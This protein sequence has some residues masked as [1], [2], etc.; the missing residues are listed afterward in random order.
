MLNLPPLN[1]EKTNLLLPDLRT[2]E[3]GL[4]STDA[5]ELAACLFSDSIL[6]KPRLHPTQG[7][8][9]LKLVS[10]AEGRSES[11][12]SVNSSKKSRSVYKKFWGLSQLIEKNDY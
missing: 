6:D 12:K 3:A 11:K 2:L 9:A 5:D 10:E 4:T 1:G 7:S 8:A